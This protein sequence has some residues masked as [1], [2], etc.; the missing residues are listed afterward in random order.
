MM[1]FCW[2]LLLGA[3]LSADVAAFA[4]TPAPTTPAQPTSPATPASATT[5]ALAAFQ[6]ALAKLAQMT[7][8]EAQFRFTNRGGAGLPVEYQ[9]RCLWMP[10]RKVRYELQVRQ[11]DLTATTRMVCDG[12]QHWRWVELDGKRTGQT[13]QLADLDLA[14]SLIAL[15]VLAPRHQ[16]RFKTELEQEYGFAGILPPLQDVAEKIA[17]DPAVSETTLAMPERGTVPVIVLRGT[18]KKQ[19]LEKIAPVKPAN[20]PP[21]APD[22]AAAWAQRQN[23]V[24]FPRRCLV[25]LDKGTGLPVRLEWFGPERREGEEVLLMRQDYLA[26][27]SVA[28]AQA[29]PRFTLA[30]ADQ[31]Q[32]EW[33]TLT[34]DELREQLNLRRQLLQEA[35]RA[36]E[37]LAR[38]RAREADKDAQKP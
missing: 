28:A 2:C 4:Q 29:E 24:G 11:G 27:T 22:Y 20:A 14:L 35:N 12:K 25:Y 31:Q 26:F 19:V 17:F 33:K 37:N 6:T 21:Q 13:F 10:G 16:G 32:V 3:V 8:L 18:W 23:W 5:P 36:E 34:P 9:G 15:D 7:P 1:Q 38:Q 30:A